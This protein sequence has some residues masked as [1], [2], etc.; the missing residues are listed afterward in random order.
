MEQ[1]RTLWIVS[2]V[3]V[4]LLV[5]VGAALIMYSPAANS[6]NVQKTPAI[7]AARGSAS[8]MGAPNFN[9]FGN[10]FDKNEPPL[11]PP[12]FGNEGTVPVGDTI[13]TDNVTVFANNATVY[14]NEST[15]FDMND[16]KKGLASNAT[17][18]A[19]SSGTTIN[20]LP[21]KD[22]DSVKTS[23]NVTYAPAPSKN[24]VTVK[25]APKTVAKA[26]PK[27]APKPQPK[28]APKA[29]P[30]PK[31]PDTFWIQIAAYEM[32]KNADE[33]RSSLEDKKIKAEVFTYETKGK[34]YYRV[35]VGPYTT[36]S[37][38]Q[39]WQKQIASQVPFD[40][41]ASYVVAVK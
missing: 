20:V 34:L 8:N 2:A 17:E 10:Q 30:A 28:P 41:S 11:P 23:V 1:K 29:A 21:P 38:A 3:G 36:K 12:S 40:T 4:F 16:L 15:A 5:V 37:E 9:Q 32:K 14:G 18:N 7:A 25:T 19:N 35:R 27:V 13:S 33:I 39:Y 24:E 31:T 22:A 6:G 26:E